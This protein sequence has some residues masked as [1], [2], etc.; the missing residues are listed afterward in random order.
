[1]DS[2]D[3]KAS[4]KVQVHVVEDLYVGDQDAIDPAYHAK[5]KIL[6]D[7]IQQMGM[8]RYQYYLFVVAG[9]GWFA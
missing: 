6:N 5:A 8:G 2:S 7:V 3:E 9:F 4:P 1:M